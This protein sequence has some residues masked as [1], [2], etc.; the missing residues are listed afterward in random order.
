MSLQG[1]KYPEQYSSVE[2]DILVIHFV[3]TSP[4][5]SGGSCRF[6]TGTL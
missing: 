6:S 3:K 2:N 1:S 4:E 5:A